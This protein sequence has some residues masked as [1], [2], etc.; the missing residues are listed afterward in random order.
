MN[1]IYPKSSSYTVIFEPGHEKI[2]F[3]EYRPGPTQSGSSTTED[4]YKLETWD[5]GGRG[6]V[7]SM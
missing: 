1:K 7:L 6:N 2:C 3:L 5:L 4:R